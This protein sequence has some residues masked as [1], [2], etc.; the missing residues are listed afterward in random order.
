MALNCT[1]SFLKW[2]SKKWIRK[3]VN[4]VDKQDDEST[5]HFTYLYNITFILLAFILYRHCK[6]QKT[7]LNTTVFTIH[8]ESMTWGLY[9]IGSL[10]W[11]IKGFSYSRVSLYRRLNKNWEL[12]PVYSTIR[13]WLKPVW[14]VIL[15]SKL[16]TCNL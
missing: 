5:R 10:Y 16:V 7:E 3:K 2:H 13:F 4:N 6:Q 11:I 12:N 9:N 8:Y 14:N 1:Y 15:T